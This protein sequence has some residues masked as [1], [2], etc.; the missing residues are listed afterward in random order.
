MKILSI[1]FYYF[2]EFIG[3]SYLPK[4]QKRAV[5][6]LKNY[7]TKND[8]NLRK[9]SERNSNHQERFHSKKANTSARYNDWKF[10]AIFG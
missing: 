9:P 7:S 4:F 2:L 6:N 3:T 1:K 10:V 8:E 5:T